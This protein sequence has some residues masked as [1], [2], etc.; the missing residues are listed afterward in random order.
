MDGPRKF[1]SPLLQMG[2]PNARMADWCPLNPRVLG[3]TR[4]QQLTI[5]TWLSIRCTKLKRRHR[6]LIRSETHISLHSNRNPRRHR[7]DLRTHSQLLT[8]DMPRSHLLILNHKRTKALRISV[9]H[10]KR[11][12]DSCHQ[13]PRCPN[14]QIRTLMGRRP[15]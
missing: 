12:L 7:V 2:I 8:Q 4:M 3:P 5:N 14:T 1:L 13:V 6:R 10:T 11:L 9:S 15:N